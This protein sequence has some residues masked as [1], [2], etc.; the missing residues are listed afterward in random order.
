MDTLCTTAWQGRGVC[1]YVG[2]R[3]QLSTPRPNFPTFQNRHVPV[4]LGAQG[5]VGVF[6]NCWAAIVVEVTIW[7]GKMKNKKQK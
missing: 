7:G 6:P 5:Y 1:M 2:F 3:F 4:F